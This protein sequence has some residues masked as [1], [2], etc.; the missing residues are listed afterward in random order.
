[1]PSVDLKFP[2]IGKRIPSDHG[3][4]LY[5]A[6]SKLLPEVHDLED[7]S[8]R[9]ISGIPDRF[10]NLTLGPA[11]SLNIRIDHNHIPLFLKL[12]G[13]ELRIADDTIRLKV[14]VTRL[15][16]PRSVLYSRLVTIKGFLN[17]MDFLDAVKRQLKAM[18]IEKD[19]I[20]FSTGSSVNPVRKTLRIHDKEVVGFPIVIPNLEPEESIL[21]Q[22]KGIGGRR[23]MGCGCFVGIRI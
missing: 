9:G 18:G 13:K 21:I 6:I 3:Y 14:P 15:L 12:A 8:I 22:T 4:L 7:A 2:V 16:K 23:K 11:S 19:S 5:S 20:L 17:P 1:M 10:R